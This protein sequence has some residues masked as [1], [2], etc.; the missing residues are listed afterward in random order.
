MEGTVVP[1]LRS[2]QQGFSG[3]EVPLLVLKI[4]HD[5][6]LDPGFETKRGHTDHDLSRQSYGDGNGSWRISDA[7][8]LH[9]G[10]RLRVKTGW[11]P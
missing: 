2:I 10:S 8:L 9:D 11:L 3:Q 1:I 4:L 5:H 6:I 7:R